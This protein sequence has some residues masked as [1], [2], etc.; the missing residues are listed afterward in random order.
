VLVDFNDNPAAAVTNIFKFW[1]LR[2]AAFA[3]LPETIPNLGQPGRPIW[4]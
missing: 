2:H 1:L 3:G 4:R